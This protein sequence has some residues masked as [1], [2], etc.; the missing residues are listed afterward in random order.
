MVTLSQVGSR[1]LMQFRGHSQVF[2]LYMLLLFLDYR[3]ETCVFGFLCAINSERGQVTSK[4][5]F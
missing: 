1:H 5:L 2:D 3:V 4:V